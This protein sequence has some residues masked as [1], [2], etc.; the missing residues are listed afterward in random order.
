MLSETY[1][2]FVKVFWYTSLMQSVACVLSLVIFVVVTCRLFRD[3]RNAARMVT[4]FQQLQRFFRAD[5]KLHKK[6]QQ[7]GYGVNKTFACL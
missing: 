4:G 3:L 6:L 1:A 5:P 2:P 7:T